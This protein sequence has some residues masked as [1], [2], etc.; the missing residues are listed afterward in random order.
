MES[1]DGGSGAESLQQFMALTGCDTYQASFLLEAAHGDFNVAL[2]M[3]YG[4][5]CYLRSSVHAMY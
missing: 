1:D 2:N 5:L 3:Y 4:M